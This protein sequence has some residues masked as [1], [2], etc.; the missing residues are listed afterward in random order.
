LVRR[1]LAAKSRS[2]VDQLVE[3]IELPVL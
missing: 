2:E 3:G 1:S